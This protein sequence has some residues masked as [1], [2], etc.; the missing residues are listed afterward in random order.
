M[1]EAN[2][3]EIRAFVERIEALDEEK[4]AL[5]EDRKELLAE[6]KGRGYDSK[7]ILKIV[8]LRKRDRDDVAEEE[9][10]LALYLSALGG[11]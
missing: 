10:I 1:V 11:A 7:V 3:D 9:A 8:A 4:R 6:L 5:A 2:G